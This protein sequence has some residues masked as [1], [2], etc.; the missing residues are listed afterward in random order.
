MFLSLEYIVLR[1]SSYFAPRLSYCLVLQPPVSNASPVTPDFLSDM[2][3]A[4]CSFYLLTVRD[5]VIAWLEHTFHAVE[6]SYHV[7]PLTSLFLS[8]VV[9]VSCIL[10]GRFVNC[11][12]FH[13]T[14]PFMVIVVLSSC[15]AVFL[16]FTRLP[17]CYKMTLSHS[18][19]VL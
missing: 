15:P 9:P 16:Y 11:A 2:I 12:A 14:Y 8:R 10:S 17:W 19:P 7:N 13:S 3:A 18:S 6:T 1:L 4:S 5:Y